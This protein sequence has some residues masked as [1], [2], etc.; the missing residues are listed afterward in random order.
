MN[1][2][3]ATLADLD[4]V[5]VLYRLAM[6]E[7]EELG[8]Y[9]VSRE[10]SAWVSS[11]DALK[12]M[13]ESP[14]AHIIVCEEKVVVGFGLATVIRLE[15]PYVPQ[16]VGKSVYTYILPEYRGG[17]TAKEIMYAKM[18]WCRSKGATFIEAYTTAKNR[19]R[20]LM[21]RGGYAPLGYELRKML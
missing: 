16:V 9:P 17:R 11:Y 13:M 6:Q 21:E 8:G 1:I 7:V 19:A 18:A 20:V 2:R 3:P 14:D 12:S 15:D 10:A 4:D 5:F